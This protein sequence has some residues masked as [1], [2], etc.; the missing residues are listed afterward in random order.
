MSLTTQERQIVDT[1]VAQALTYEVDG[2]PDSYTFNRD[3]NAYNG[4]LL[5][6]GETLRYV[7]QLPSKL[8]V[9]LGCG[10]SNG[11]SDISKS[12]G[13]LALTFRA[14]ALKRHEAHGRFIGDDNVDIDTVESLKS[15]KDGSV[16]CFL[17]VFSL[18]YSR[19]PRTAI[20]TIRGRLCNGG[21]LK[22][23]FQNQYVP[24]KYGEQP[25]ND[26]YNACLENGFDVAV[27]YPDEYGPETLLAV[28]KPLQNGVTAKQLID[29]DFQGMMEM[30][31]GS[32]K[33]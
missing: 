10:T 6:V 32:R 28:K 30:I 19:I 21:V 24:G 26:F 7:A 12:Y 13:G 17:A 23:V 9:D 11:I 25:M 16:G 8:V 4:L 27:M 5:G 22:A 1:Q 31:S 33:K 29:S 2:N 3:G 14:T 15:Y 20:K 18:A